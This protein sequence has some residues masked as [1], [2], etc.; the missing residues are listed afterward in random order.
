MKIE[1]S[2]LAQ[3]E[4]WLSC[5]GWSGL[6][7][8]VQPM[9]SSSVFSSARGFYISIHFVTFWYALSHFD[10]KVEKGEKCKPPKAIFFL[11]QK[12]KDPE[13]SA[14]HPCRGQSLQPCEALLD[15]CVRLPWAT[16]PLPS[17]G[18]RWMEGPCGLLKSKAESFI[19]KLI[20]L[21]FRTILGRDWPASFN[22]WLGFQWS[23]HISIRQLEP[24]L[25]ILCCPRPHSQF[26]WRLNSSPASGSGRW[27]RR[28]SSVCR[29]HHVQPRRQRW[30][31][32]FSC[33]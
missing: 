22:N 5:W 32:W 12:S 25:D 7:C 15:L 3:W 28:P 14:C 16:L 1:R 6:H 31:R 13:I 30:A 33:L 18:I 27:S 19:H 10:T 4:S 2:F 29:P 9:A 24:V 21:I 8:F 23:H 20:V 17:H 26:H 11:S